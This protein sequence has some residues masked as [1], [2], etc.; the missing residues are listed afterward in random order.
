MPLIKLT[1]YGQASPIRFILI[2]FL[3]LF[4]QSV[5]VFALNRPPTLIRNIDLSTINENAPVN[6]HVFQ[7]VAHDP[8]GKLLR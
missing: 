2:N 8:E 5:N 7:L 4:L 1:F 3:L 6:S